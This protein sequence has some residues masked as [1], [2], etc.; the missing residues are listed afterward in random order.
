M[1]SYRPGSRRGYKRSDGRMSANRLAWLRTVIGT[2]VLMK[3]YDDDSHLQEGQETKEAIVEQG[4]TYRLLLPR[5]TGGRPVTYNLTALTHEEFLALKTFFMKVFDL[6]EPVVVLRDRN[7]EDAY[8]KGD[9]SFARIYRQ[10]PQLVIR[11]GAHGEDV[12]RIQLGPEDVSEGYEPDGDSGGGLRGA[13]DDV[14]AEVSPH[15]L[16]EDDEPAT[17]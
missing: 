12:Q 16:S 8:S 14:A 1:A 4:D 7:A 15:P 6:V 9:D 11:E 5:P 3:G 2:F 17:D 13:G 10:A